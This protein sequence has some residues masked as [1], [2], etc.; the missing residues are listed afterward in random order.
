MAGAADSCYLSTLSC[1]VPLPGRLTAFLSFLPALP[2]LEHDNAFSGTGY[3]CH[4]QGREER[5][6][7][8]ERERER[9]V[10]KKGKIS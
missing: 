6:R 1:T 5:K 10:E 7:E 9:E 2:D 3:N 8:G 4:Q